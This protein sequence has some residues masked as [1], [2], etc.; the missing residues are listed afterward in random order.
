MTGH[1]D[2]ETA[3]RTAGFTPLCVGGNCMAWGRAA[4]DNS[5]E[6][7]Q[8]THES[9][10]LDADADSADWM[11]GRFHPDGLFVTVRDA[12]TLDD[13]VALAPHVPPC[14]ADHDDFEVSRQKLETARG[15]A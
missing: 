1:T 10:T 3:L 6:T 14:R 8:V 5:G 15:T 9:M 13:A 2:T 11:L 7:I 12:M 4:A